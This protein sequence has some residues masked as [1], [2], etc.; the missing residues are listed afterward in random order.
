M[1]I[2][3]KKEIL[4]EYCEKEILF[5]NKHDKLLIYSAEIQTHEVN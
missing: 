5:T 1:E 4:H 3:L 2:F